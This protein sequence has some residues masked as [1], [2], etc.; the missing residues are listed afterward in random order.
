VFGSVSI[1]QIA[2]REME[3]KTQRPRSNSASNERMIR[4]LRRRSSCAYTNT[5]GM[6]QPTTP[7]PTKTIP[8]AVFERMFGH[9]RQH[10]LGRAS[11]GSSG[12]EAFSISLQR[13]G[14][15]RKVP[16]A[17]QVKLTEYKKKTRLGHRDIERRIQD[18]GGRRTAG[19]S[20]RR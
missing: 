11:H 16:A 15:T 10:R 9:E 17:R 20:G 19:A 7:L 3:G 8:R 6:A 18:G 14:E 1:D 5:I 2:A 12:T 13:G 4:V